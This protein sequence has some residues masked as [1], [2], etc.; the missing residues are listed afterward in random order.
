MN[1]RK[2]ALLS[3]C[4]PS[5][6]CKMLKKGSHCGHVRLSDGPL[7][8]TVGPRHSMTG[9]ANMVFF[10]LTPRFFGSLVSYY[11]LGRDR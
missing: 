7:H 9:V 10:L 2:S 4:V 8:G 5:Y 6:R 3:I 11:F 1:V